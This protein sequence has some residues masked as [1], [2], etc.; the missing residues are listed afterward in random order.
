MSTI[1]SL[2]I[3]L[4]LGSFLNVLAYRLPRRLGFISGRSFCPDCKIDIAPTDLM[5]IVSY[6]ALR[7]RCR[8]CLTRISFRY[9]A[10]EI[11][12]AVIV[13]QLSANLFLSYGAVNLLFAIILSL[14]FSAIALIDY[15]HFIIP[16]KIL[17]AILLLIVVFGAFEYLGLVKP[18]LNIISSNHLYWGLFFGAASYLIWRVSDGKWLGFGDVKLMTI[19]GFVFGIGSLAI[20]YGSIISGAV[21]GLSLIL[22]GKASSKTQLPFGVFLGTLSIIYLIYGWGVVG[23]FRFFQMI[24]EI[25]G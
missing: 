2:V 4:C 21:V 20:V 14:F 17:L 22:A 15:D 8:H 25:A 6:I 19:L 23:D 18:F 16:D 9:P 7:G 1:L 11:I 24:Y 5:P 13:W 12:F 10:V 3:G